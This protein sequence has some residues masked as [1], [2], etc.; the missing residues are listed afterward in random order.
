MELNQTLRSVASDLVYTICSGLNVRILT[1]NT[2]IKEHKDNQNKRYLD[3]FV[4]GNIVLV[5][6]YMCMKTMKNP[7][8]RLR[9]TL[10]RL[11]IKQRSEQFPF[12][13]QFIRTYLD[14]IGLH[15][16]LV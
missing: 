3:I 13:F 7:D 14:L 11:L 15:K 10:F 12:L 2:V 8:T 9:H 1:I 4:Y 6:G 16:N 5:A